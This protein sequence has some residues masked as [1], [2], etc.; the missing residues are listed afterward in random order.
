MKVQ[1]H[2]FLRGAIQFLK[3]QL[4]G[5]IIFWGTYL[6]Y[7]ISDFFFG[8]PELWALALASLIAHGLFFIVSREWVFDAATGKR[9]QRQEVIRFI[10][11]MGFNYF[12]NLAIIEGL[13]SFFGITP[14]IGQFVSGFFFA[15]WSYLGL[16]LWVFTGD[17]H[18][19]P[20]AYDRK[21][22]AGHGV[23]SAE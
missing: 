5:N 11:F 7:F 23:G 17:K 10:V 15:V 16:K 1:R 18:Y 21:K 9:K 8:H 6:G 2:R 14:Y 12:L 22:E 20:I 3:L 19:A 13:R 4:A